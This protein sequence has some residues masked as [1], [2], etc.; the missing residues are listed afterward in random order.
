M[1]AALSREVPIREYSPRGIK[2]SITGNGNASKEQVAAMLTSILKVEELPKDLDATDG[3]AVA[4][5]HYFQ[6]YSKGK[7]KGK[8]GYSDW[9]SYIKKNPKRKL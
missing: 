5:C 9:K 6:A 3:T 1:A 7:A 4:L 2:R 8:G